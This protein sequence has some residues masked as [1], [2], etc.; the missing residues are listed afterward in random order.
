MTK[1]E[2]FQLLSLIAV[3]YDSYEINQRKVDEWHV[4]LKHD[5]YHRLEKNLRSHAEISPYPPRISELI[6]KPEHGSRFIPDVEETLGF[7]YQPIQRASEEVVQQSLAE[8]RK[9]LGIRRGE[10]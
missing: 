6:R 10:N 2:V 9:I 7:L 1:K 8:I 3:Y 4:L 5:S